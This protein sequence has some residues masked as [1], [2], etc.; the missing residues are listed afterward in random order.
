VSRGNT[1]SQAHPVAPRAEF[2]RRSDPPPSR[3]ARAARIATYA[4]LVLIVVLVVGA[5]SYL[6]WTPVVRSMVDGCRP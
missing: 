6:M 4:L 1:V 2:L 3:L 5:A